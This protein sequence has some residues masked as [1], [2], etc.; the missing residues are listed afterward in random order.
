MAMI[1]RRALKQILFTYRPLVYSALRTKP[2]L[3]N[4]SIPRTLKNFLKFPLSLLLPTMAAAGVSS[5][6]LQKVIDESEALYEK[7]EFDKMYNLLIPHKESNDANILWRCARAATE[8]GKMG[9]QEERKQHIFEAWGYI[10][11]ALELDDNNFACH[12]WYGILLDYTAEY[13]GTKKRI[14]NAFKVKEHFMKAIELNPTDATTM[15]CLG[16]WCF[17]FADMAWYERK[18]ASVI[19]GTPPTSTYEEALDYF[20]RAEK[21]EPGFYNKNNKMIGLTYLRLKDKQNAKIYFEKTVNYP[22]AVTN[23]DIQAIKD[24]EDHL[25]SL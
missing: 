1:T 19:F 25:K 15:Y 17:L 9:S 14:S 8:K 13:E 21:A 24:A 3:F 10:S 12:K 23:D 2:K 22:N 16:Y 11:K 20:L 7:K 5:P 4:S 18:I 6:D